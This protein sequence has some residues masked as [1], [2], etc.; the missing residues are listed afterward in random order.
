MSFIVTV[1]SGNGSMGEAAESIF[2]VRVEDRQDAKDVARV[3][4]TTLGASGHEGLWST[5]D[6]INTDL[7]ENPTDFTGISRKLKKIVDD[8]FGS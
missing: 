5:F 1:H 2:T 6:E 7:I 4:Q 3:L 8:R